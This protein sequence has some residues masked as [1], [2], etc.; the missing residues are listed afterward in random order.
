MHDTF[1]LKLDELIVAS[2]PSNEAVDLENISDKR[3]MELLKQFH[4]L[5]GQIPAR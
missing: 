2:G 5:A 4:A 3:A 1:R